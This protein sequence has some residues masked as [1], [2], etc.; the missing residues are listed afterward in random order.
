MNSVD[1][2]VEKT[3]DGMELSAMQTGKKKQKKK[4]KKKKNKRKEKR[5]KKKI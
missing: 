1:H 2:S 5:N 3:N 4:T